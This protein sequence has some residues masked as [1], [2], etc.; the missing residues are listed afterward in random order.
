MI[1]TVIVIVTGSENEKSAVA[2]GH[3]LIVTKIVVVAVVQGVVTEE[4]DVGVGIE[5]KD[6]T[7]NEVIATVVVIATDVGTIEIEIGIG[8]VETEIEIIKEVVVAR[9]VAVVI[10]DVKEVVIGMR[11]EVADTAVGIGTEIETEDHQKIGHQIEKIADLRNHL[12][13]VI[14]FQMRKLLPQQ[15]D[16]FQMKKI[17]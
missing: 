6:V 16:C 11:K 3:L 2:D 12:K 5:V 17:D 1:G 15:I 14:K 10:V 7:E 8:I 4:K 13:L 9:E